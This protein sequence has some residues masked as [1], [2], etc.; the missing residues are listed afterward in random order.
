MDSCLCLWSWSEIIVYAPFTRL[1]RN[2]EIPA[3]PAVCP[4]NNR[5]TDLRHRAIRIISA[6]NLNISSFCA[7]AA[8]WCFHSAPALVKSGGAGR[9]CEENCVVAKSF[10]VRFIICK[11]FIS[12][13]GY[14]SRPVLLQPQTNNACNSG[15]ILCPTRANREDSLISC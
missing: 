1:R 8:I 14:R 3:L 11:V 5:T 4:H 15:N 6:S 7:C 9:R 10:F 12:F 2:P 13:P